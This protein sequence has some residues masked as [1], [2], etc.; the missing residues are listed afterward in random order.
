YSL[1]YFV[2]KNFSVAMPAIEAEL[3]I[4][5][6]QLGIFLTLNGIIYGFSRFLNG[7]LA[8]RFSKK[9][10]MVLGLGL[11]AMVNLLICFSPKMDGIMNLLDAE[12]KAT[13]GLVYLIGGLWVVNGYLQGMGVPPCLSLL[14]NWIRPSQLATRQSVWNA[15]HSLGA[16]FVAVL[17]GWLLSK[18]GYSA[19]NLCFAVP[20]V[21]ALVGI[22]VILIGTKDKPAQVGLPPVEKIDAMEKGEGQVEEVKDAK[23]DDI[24]NFQYKKVLSKMVFKNPYIWILAGANF[25]VYVIRFTILDWG[26]SFLTQ[27][28][29]M[30]ISQAASI[31]ATSELIGGI[32]GMLIAGWATDHL[33]KSKAQ[34]TCLF[35]TIGATASFFLFWKTPSVA[36]SVVFLV[37]SAFFIYGPQALLGA[38]ASL[39]ATKRAAA[40][41]NGIL[42]IV[43]Y[44]SPIVS[45]AVF[46]VLAD[47]SW[48]L[49]FLVSVI[50][51]TI[52]CAIIAIMW[53]APANG[54]AKLEKVLAEAKEEE[55][56]LAKE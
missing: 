49:V 52:G 50:F 20:A 34:W 43:G 46:G 1:Y 40:T 31:V 19:W 17:C 47:K 11:S 12:G 36:V 22:P 15:S 21:I 10:I 2:R 7:M 29:G 6:A 32:L 18:Y 5:K 14:A 42:G 35:C 48:D 28:K 9:I 51:G 4:S 26:S 13:L 8:D 56:K 54:Y 39:Q 33:F 37:L 44:L 41:A 3:G 38:C 23:S 25:C 16:G 24:S 45:G 53:S 55:A 27:Y 30:D